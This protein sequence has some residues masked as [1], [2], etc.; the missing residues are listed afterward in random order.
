MQITAYIA[1]LRGFQEHVPVRR[2]VV[3][4]RNTVRNEQD[5]VWIDFGEVLQSDVSHLNEARTAAGTEACVHTTGHLFHIVQKTIRTGAYRKPLCFLPGAGVYFLLLF[6][7]SLP[8]GN[9]VQGGYFMFSAKPHRG[10]E[11][12]NL[13][14]QRTK[15]CTYFR[16]LMNI[17]IKPFM[18]HA[19]V[20]SF[21][22]R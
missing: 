14:R 8:G 5:F 2:R 18:I 4:Q 9:R 15:I 3:L 20:Q 1:T 13:P 21:Q 19:L 11:S 22:I 17:C 16:R 6:L 12:T 7:N 10:N